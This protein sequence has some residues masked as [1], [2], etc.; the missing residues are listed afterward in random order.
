MSMT[1]EREL[2]LER[3]RQ[4]ALRLEQ[5]RSECGALLKVCEETISGVRDAAVQQYAAAGL[6][7]LDM[8]LHLSDQ[9]GTVGAGAGF[10]LGFAALHWAFYRYGLPYY[11]E[12]LQQLP[13]EA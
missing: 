10:F 8:A 1:G 5:V 4:E 9:N 2:R 13:P 11:R 7:A 3:A 12:A 6:S